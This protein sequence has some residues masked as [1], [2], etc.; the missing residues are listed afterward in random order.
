M[1]KRCPTCGQVFSILE[2]VL[3]EHNTGYQ[4]HRCWNRVRATGGGAASF[5]I[6]GQKRARTH[7]THRGARTGCRK[8]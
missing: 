7:N 3:S 4:C 2:V 5:R 8:A 6:G 1:N